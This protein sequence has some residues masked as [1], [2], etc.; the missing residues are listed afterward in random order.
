MPGNDGYLVELDVFHQLRCLDDV[1]KALYPQRYNNWKWK[2]DGK[3]DYDAMD[4]DHW[5]T[6]SL[7]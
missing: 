7:R 5:G 6:N 3:V 1:R 2:E 4:W